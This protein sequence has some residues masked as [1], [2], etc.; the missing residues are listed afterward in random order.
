MFIPICI[1][2]LMSLCFCRADEKLNLY[3]YP[4]FNM[5]MKKIGQLHST[6]GKQGEQI[7]VIEQ[8]TIES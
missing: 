1:A 5:T 4:D 8:E 6:I 3:D 2:F 7:I